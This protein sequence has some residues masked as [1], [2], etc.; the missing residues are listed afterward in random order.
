MNKKIEATLYKLLDY[1]T[2][3][4]R[5]YSINDDHWKVA[6][7]LTRHTARELIA[8]VESEEE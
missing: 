2:R 6:L 4:L 7:S 3:T 8:L 1:V 5:Y